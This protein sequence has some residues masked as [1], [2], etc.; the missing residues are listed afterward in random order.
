MSV[1]TVAEALGRVKVFSELVG[2]VNLVKPFPVPP[3]AEVR[4]PVMSV[5]PESR[6]MAAL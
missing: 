6:E 5:E 3:L 2:P 1:K 4:I